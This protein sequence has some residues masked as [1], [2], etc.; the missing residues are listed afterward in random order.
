M[1]HVARRLAVLRAVCNLKEATVR[2]LECAA[3]PSSAPFANKSSH[4]ANWVARQWPCYFPIFG[5]RCSNYG[6]R[7]P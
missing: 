5:K 2:C 3:N 6:L 4:G 7:R 1:T